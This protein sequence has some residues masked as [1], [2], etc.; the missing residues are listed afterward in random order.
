MIV[1]KS[2]RIGIVP[3]EQL[4][5]RPPHPQV[6]DVELVPLGL[7][8]VPPAIHAEDHVVPGH[9]LLPRFAGKLSRHKTGAEGHRPRLVS[10]TGTC[11]LGRDRIRSV[12][13]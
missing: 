10:T 4:R 2:Q 13:L 7:F 1:P 11:Q 12:D 6:E 8:P 9:T 5:P 3:K